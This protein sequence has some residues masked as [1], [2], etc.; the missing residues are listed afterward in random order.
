MEHGL[1]APK[2]LDGMFSWVLWDKEQDR[3]IA[4]RDPIDI[5][6]FYLGRSSSTPGA[7]YSLPSSSAYTPSVTTSL[8]SLP[9]TSMTPRLTS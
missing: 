4:A 5:T 6:S 2:R 7:V 3:V 8:P 1:D 9:A